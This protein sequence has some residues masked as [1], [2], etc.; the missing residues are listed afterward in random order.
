VGELAERG[1]HAASSSSVCA[2]HA[3]WIPVAVVRR[4]GDAAEDFDS[5][6]SAAAGLAA[7]TGGA[8]THSEMAWLLSD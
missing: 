6:T 8:H 7:E 2:H 3:L 4:R 1:G 5:S